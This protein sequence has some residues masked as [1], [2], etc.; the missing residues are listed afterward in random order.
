MPDP[1]EVEY[2]F[3][4]FVKSQKDAHVYEMNGVSKGPIDTGVVAQGNDLLSGDSLELVRNY[5]KEAPENVGFSLMAL[6][7][8][9]TA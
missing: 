5:M 1:E 9:S 4:C 7:P 2:H 8:S 3:I 6:V